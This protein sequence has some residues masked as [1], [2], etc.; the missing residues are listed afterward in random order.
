MENSAHATATGAFVLALVV[1]L[2]AA[3]F[4]L[5]GGTMRGVPY[6]L[7]TG[8]SVAGLSTGAPVRVLGVDVGEVQSITLDPLNPRRVRVRALIHPGVRLMEGT[9]ATISYLGLSGMAYVEL[10]FPEGASQPLLSTAARPARIPMQASGFAQLAGSGRTLIRTLTGTLQHVNAV[11]TPQNLDNVTL[12]IRHLNQAAAG[13]DVL[14]HD[15]QPAARDADGTLKRL[16]GVMGPLRRTVGDADTLLVRADAPGGAMDAI[17]SG[18]QSTGQAAHGVELALVY[19][20]LPQLDTLARRLSRASDS[21][22][23]LLQQLQSQPQSLLFGLPSQPPGPG[24]P[25]FGRAANK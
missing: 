2:A 25:G 15:F 13:A 4:W 17:R 12:L 5:E 11:L 21:L 8:S 18:A 1:L 22:D 10:E 7:V 24:E 3:A 23:L 6:D 14:M 16:D 20:T 9:R 19:Q